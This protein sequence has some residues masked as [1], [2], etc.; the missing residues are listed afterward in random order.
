LERRVSEVKEKQEERL[1][2][3]RKQS[4]QLEPGTMVMAVDQTRGSKW[5]PVYE[6][7]FE[8]VQQHSGGSYSLK[9]SLGRILERRQTIDMLKVITEPEQ[10]LEKKSGQHYSV[11]AI[12]R[13]KKTPTGFKFLVKWKHY[14]EEENS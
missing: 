7:P 5:D 10:E 13:H 3:T 2:T 4:R 12:R 8:V 1:N 9:N 14:P 6:G 11:E